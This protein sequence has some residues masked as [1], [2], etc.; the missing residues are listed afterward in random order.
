MESKAPSL[1]VVCEVCG[2]YFE[3]RRGLSSHARLHLRQLGVTLSETS[4]APIDLLYQI[5]QERDGP[6]PSSSTP[7]IAPVPSSNKNTQEGPGIPKGPTSKS[8][9]SF[10]HGNKVRTT[11]L[12]VSPSVR[13]GSGPSL[14][15]A[16][17]RLSGAST[18]TTS[19][20]LATAKPLWAPQ[21]SDAPLTLAMNSNDEV[22]VCQ[23]CGAWY[24]TR[25][26]LA[27]HARAH[28][29]QFGVTENTETKGG[30]IEFLYQL[31]DAEDLKPIGSRQEEPMNLYTPSKPS[32]KR[33]LSLSPSPKLTRGS[34]SPLQSPSSKQAKPSDEFVCILCGEEFGNRKGLASHSR[35]HL[36]GFGITDLMGKA[37]AIDTVHQ[38]V[39]SGVLAAVRPTDDTTKAVFPDPAP[40]LSPSPSISASKAP[41]P[42]PGPAKSTQSPLIPLTKAPKAKKGFRLAV[43]PLN[44]KPKPEPEES[45][46]SS[47]LGDSSPST[48]WPSPDGI[49]KSLS[50]EIESIPLIP[51]D[52]CGQFFDSRKALSCHA[53]AHLR[54]LGITWSLNESPIE[55]LQDVM[56]QGGEIKKEP[57]SVGA[58]SAWSQPTWAPRVPKKTLE[59]SLETASP[60]TFTP[61]L[62]FSLKGK[63][64]QG[65]SEP[66]SATCCEL[67]GFDFEN[68]KA[69]SSHARAHLR[70]L[71]VTE[72]RVKV[73]PIELLREMIQKEPEKVAEITRRYRMGDLHI[74][75]V[76]CSD[77]ASMFHT[78]LAYESNNSMCENY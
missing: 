53:R 72:W 40:P 29:R 10:K 61:P 75:K 15:A 19:G 32:L 16:N 41:N 8:K 36:R 27:S 63:P 20:T 64:S 66:V 9:G 45:E 30:P 21:A 22:H 47:P 65:K 3:T 23:L 34:P 18:S 70:Q 38:L 39:D 44:R 33:Q 24:E 5:V 6:F 57:S 69:L 35:S 71:G 31:M 74:K 60:A 56:L 7:L 13:K 43:D 26:G 14:S 55:T 17:S 50:A 2:A 46:V 37:S 62:D 68:R 73:S 78:F 52:F 12:S 42:A 76:T 4:G 25:K 49:T 28:L 54:Q 1:T 58:K 67:C 11:G 51:C 48:Q 77:F 59:N